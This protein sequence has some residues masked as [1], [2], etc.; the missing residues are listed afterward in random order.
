MT[1][2]ATTTELPYAVN[3]WGSH[4]DEGNDDCD[5]GR[6]YATLDEAARA[7][8]DI[9]AM[10][11]Q[12]DAEHPE[13]I[14]PSLYYADWVYAELTGPDVHLVRRNPDER[15]IRRRKRD[16]AQSDREWQREQAHQA[17]MAFGC[18]GYNDA[19]GW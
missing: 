1:T 19:M 6:D 5:T 11:K 4:P 18:D 14:R 3:L 12:W 16:A 13:S 7:F 17:G 2:I 15:A 8:Q 9:G 10:L